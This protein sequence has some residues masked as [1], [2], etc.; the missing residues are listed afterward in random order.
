MYNP[1]LDQDYN[2]L[3][4][5]EGLSK[6]NKYSKQCFYQAQSPKYNNVNNVLRVATKL[7][8]VNHV[9]PNYIFAPFPIYCTNLPVALCLN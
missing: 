1:H 8:Y 6:F 2:D 3:P 7:H 4:V 9:T 5:E